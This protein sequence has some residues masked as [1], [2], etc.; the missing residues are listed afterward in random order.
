MVAAVR[1]APRQLPDNAIAIAKRP[2]Q[3]GGIVAD[4]E[5]APC[6]LVQA[7]DREP[8]LDEHGE[9]FIFERVG[10]VLVEEPLAKLPGDWGGRSPQLS[11]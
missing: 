11:W 2:R 9:Q 8:G 6:G 10:P 1:P 3:I 4:Q 5:P 7:L